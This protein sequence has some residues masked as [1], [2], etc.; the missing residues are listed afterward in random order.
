MLVK[1]FHDATS[2]GQLHWHDIALALLQLEH[3]QTSGTLRL[4]LSVRLI[5]GDKRIDDLQ[6]VKDVRIN[7]VHATFHA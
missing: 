7:G 3:W 5:S 6:P 4:P 1:E 2:K